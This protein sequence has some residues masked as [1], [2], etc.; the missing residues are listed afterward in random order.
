MAAH[1]DPT[2]EMVTHIQRL[3][4]HDKA[5]LARQL[6]DELG[7]L[8]IGAVM[9]LALLAPR[10][11]AMGGDS[12]QKMGRVRQALQSAIVLAATVDD[13]CFLSRSWGTGRSCRTSPAHWSASR[14]NRCDT[15]FALWVVQ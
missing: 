14:S 9:D 4:E 3:V 10:I 15:E 7:G 13:Q 1:C 6:H 12:P 2:L 11:A 8:L 5:V